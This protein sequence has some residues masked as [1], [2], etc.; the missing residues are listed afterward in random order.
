MIKKINIYL[1]A[2]MLCFVCFSYN[3]NAKVTY[4]YSE[5]IETKFDYDF[6]K[7][8]NDVLTD[9]NINYL[10]NYFENYNETDYD[11]KVCYATLFAGT[12]LY[13]QCFSEYPYRYD[14]SGYF[15]SYFSSKIPHLFF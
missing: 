9:D 4:S 6:L 2:F 1:I 13:I 11:I 7:S 15:Y 12:Q 10:N 14:V 8:V 5:T 3:T